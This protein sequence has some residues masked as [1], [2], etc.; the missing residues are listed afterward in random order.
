[1]AS[2][3]HNPR[4]FPWR[5]VGW[6]GA[7]AL[8]LA[9]LVAMQFTKKVNWTPAD[10]AFAAA[11]FGLVGGTFELAVRKGSSGRYR[12]A[13]AVA[14]GTAF[15]LIWINAA[16]GIIGDEGNPANLMFLAVIAIALAG[17]IVAKFRASGMAVA[18]MVAA[19]AEALVGAIATLFRLGANEPPFFPGVIIL[20]LTFSIGWF[21]SAWLF[22]RAA[23]EGVYGVSSR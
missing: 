19:G 3:L 20:I 5:V 7:A 2:K 14:L 6:G 16:V 21:L 12:L 4:A 23:Q 1:M 9:P 10:F 17:S 8:L 22:R 18:M 13:L 11:M 15:L